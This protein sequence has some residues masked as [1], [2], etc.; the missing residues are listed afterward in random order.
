MLIVIV[1][2]RSLLFFLIIAIAAPFPSNG[3]QNPNP[4]LQGRG[5]TSSNQGQQQRPQRQRVRLQ[6]TVPKDKLLSSRD[7]DA[8]QQGQI[9]IIP[10]F[11]PP[12]QIASLKLDAQNLWNQQFYATDALASYGTSLGTKFNPA[13]DR[14]VLKLSQWKDPSLGTYDTRYQLGARMAALR[15]DLAYH[16]DRPHLNSGLAVQS[17]TTRSSSATTTTATTASTTTNTFGYGSTEIS[18]TR[19]GPGAFLKRHVDEHHEELK[20]TAGWSQPTRRSVSWLIYLNDSDWDEVKDGGQLRCYP[21]TSTAVP[22][23]SQ[24]ITTATTTTTTRVGARPNGDLQLAWLRPSPLDPIER[25]V[26]L[27]A[28][29]PDNKCAMY[30]INTNTNTN[31]AETMT[32]TREQYITPDFESHPIL[33]LAGGEAL[34]KQILLERHVADR[35]YFIEPPKSRVSDLLSVWNVNNNN[36]DEVLAD[37]TPAGGTLVLFDSVALPH[38]VMPTKRRERWATSGWFHEDQQPPVGRRGRLQ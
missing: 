13:R 11:I 22:S 18:Y 19:F 23:S 34:V 16:L 28:R 38:E 37:V 24:T 17:A 26:F 32:T 4:T 6:F 31:A 12:Q 29:R 27:D 30:Y 8:I 2:R 9:A 10:N 36:N 33:Y 21:R 5:L 1:V 3:F 14:A 35:F 20:D 15:A 25:P 7:Y